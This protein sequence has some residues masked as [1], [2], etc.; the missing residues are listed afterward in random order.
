MYRAKVTKIS[1]CR[2]HYRWFEV[3][4]GY[5]KVITGQKLYWLLLLYCLVC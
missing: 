5:Y 1:V 3:N 4:R 2:G